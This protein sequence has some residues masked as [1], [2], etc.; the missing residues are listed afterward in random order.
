MDSVR[1]VGAMCR[2]GVLK[3]SGDESMTFVEIAEEKLP[4]GE[5]R[6]GLALALAAR[7]TYVCTVPYPLDGLSACQARVVPVPRQFC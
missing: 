3:V 5:M 4:G 6:E 7:T 2:G 1:V